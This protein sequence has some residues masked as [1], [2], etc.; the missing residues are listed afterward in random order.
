MSHTEVGNGVQ[1]LA[2]SL[3]QGVQHEAGNQ[4]AHQR[5]QPE[6]L[7]KQSEEK[8][9]GKEE[10]VHNVPWKFGRLG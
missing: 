9:D 4:E 7:R 10:Y 5:W 8:R 3:P 6:L 2:A 1:R